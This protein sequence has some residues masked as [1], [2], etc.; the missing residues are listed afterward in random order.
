MIRTE[1]KDWEQ[2]PNRASTIQ[3]ATDEIW[4]VA[5]L[6]DRFEN[7]TEQACANLGELSA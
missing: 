1:L 3:E 2:N 4:G 7:L 6:V 5:K